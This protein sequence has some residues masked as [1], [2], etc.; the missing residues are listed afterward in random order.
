MDEQI[1]K[2]LIEQA[3]KGS[4]EAFEKLIIHHEKT[5][6]AICLRMLCHEQEAY[7]AAQEVCVKIWRQ[8]KHFEGNAKFTTW[9]YRIATNQCLDMLR[10]QKRKDEVSLYQENK[11]K[12]EV[13]LL[14][15]EDTKASVEDHM[16]RLAMQDVM[17]LALGELKEEYR[18]IL[19]LRDMEGY[20][21]EEIARVLK[22]NNGTVKSRLSRARMA[23]KKIL[24]QNKE[25]YVSYFRQITKKEG[26]L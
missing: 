6:Y 24:M 11:E 10:K 7:D 13:H 18:E 15:Q 5:I 25:P 17:S 3:Q 2:M 4:V 22:L 19:V 21:Y 12:G 20:A 9:L 23:L 14:E 1:E 8:I 26:N 16:E